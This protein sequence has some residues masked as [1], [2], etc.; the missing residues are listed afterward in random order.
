MT[1]G[2]GEL[3]LEAEHFV[4]LGLDVSNCLVALVGEELVLLLQAGLAVLK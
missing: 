1:Y 4:G 3:A 2:N